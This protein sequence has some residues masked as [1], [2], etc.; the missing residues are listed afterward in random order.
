MLYYDSATVLSFAL[1]EIHVE[2]LNLQVMLQATLSRR[3]G[4]KIFPYSRKI[5]EGNCHINVTNSRWL[6]YV[7]TNKHTDISSSINSSRCNSRF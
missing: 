1:L 2:I 4:L 5:Q 6:F 3:K 7:D